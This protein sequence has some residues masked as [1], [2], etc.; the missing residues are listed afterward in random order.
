MPRWEESEPQWTRIPR[1][2]CYSWRR[3]IGLRKSD[4]EPED[5]QHLKPRQALRPRGT[6]F[7]LQKH[8]IRAVPQRRRQASPGAR[9]QDNVV[10]PVVSGPVRERVQWTSC[11]RQR[12][13][14]QR[15]DHGQARQE[16]MY[17]VAASLPRN[18]VGDLGILGGKIP[19]QRRGQVY[20]PL[21]CRFRNHLG[22]GIVEYDA[23][24][25]LILAA[26]LAH[27]Q[28]A[29]LG[30]SLP[31]PVPR[32][33]LRHVLSDAIEIGAAAVHK[34]LPLAPHQWQALKP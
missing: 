15:F 22:F 19:G 25:A 17:L 8:K 18:L 6:R 5:R 23:H 32:R 9:S 11:A 29:G 13:N 34:A 10:F 1:P 21:I 31:A 24:L 7:V 4:L 3:F 16:F 12:I 27:L 2:D 33:I 20:S 14:C 26:E 30:R 28:R